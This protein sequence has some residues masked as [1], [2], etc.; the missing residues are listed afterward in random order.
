MDLTCHRCERP[1]FH[2]DASGRDW[3]IHCVADEASTRRPYAKLACEALEH[4]PGHEDLIRE[5]RRR[6]S[7]L[8]AVG[9]QE[10]LP[11]YEGLMQ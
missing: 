1:A 10:P 4:L 6:Q 8:D 7:V 2:R 9:A 3:C 5:I 11:F